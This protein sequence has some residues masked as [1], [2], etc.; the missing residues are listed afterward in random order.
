M[1]KENVIRKKFK[2][3]CEMNKWS[4]WLPARVK[5]YENDI[6]GIADAIIST[7]QG[8]K[9]IQLTTLSNISARKKKIQKVLETKTISSVIEIWGWDDK[10]KYFKV[11]II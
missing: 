10:K 8:L 4:V 1:P 5:F 11:V 3:V 6:F 9:L 7:S 2:E